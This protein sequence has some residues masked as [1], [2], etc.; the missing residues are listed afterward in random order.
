[1]SELLHTLPCYE[2]DQRL[3][4][5]R[6]SKE[7]E[8]IADEI[9]GILHRLQDRL[10]EGEVRRT[11]YETLLN[12]VDTAVLVC[13]PSGITEW[14]NQAAEKLLGANPRL[15]PDWLAPDGRQV[16]EPSSCRRRSL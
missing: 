14:H 3:N 11:Y 12:R 2:G 1:M 9:N 8:H 5:H 4:E 15:S 13:Y 6:R 16:G 7:T 10:V